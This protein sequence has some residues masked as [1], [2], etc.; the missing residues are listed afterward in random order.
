MTETVVVRRI[1]SVPA[2]TSSETWQAIVDTIAEPGNDAH[3]T[4]IAATGIASMLIAE[5]YTR[6]APVVISPPVGPRVRVYTVHGPDAD[7]AISEEAALAT[8]PTAGSGWTV[9]L[10]CAEEDLTFAAASLAALSEVSVRDAALGLAAELT[11]AAADPTASVRVD[12][13]WLES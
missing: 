11:S 6:D 2:R 9:S 12:T 1:G 7:D 8:W 13:S 5:S 4:L 10:P 3:S